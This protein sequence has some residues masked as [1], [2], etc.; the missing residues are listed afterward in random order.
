MDG[1]R[2]TGIFD[3]MLAVVPGLAK[4][5]QPVFEPLGHPALA[6]MRDNE[7]FIRD[8][9]FCQGKKALASD[10]LVLTTVHSSIKLLSCLN[11]IG[12]PCLLF[13]FPAPEKRRRASTVG[14]GALQSASS[15]A[16]A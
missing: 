11:E 9:G 4:L 16:S 12:A 15:T 6:D 14:L 2:M 13:D 1:Y 7:H 8:P 10:T 5:P 3:A